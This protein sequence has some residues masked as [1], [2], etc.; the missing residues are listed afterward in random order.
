[1]KPALHVGRV[2]DIIRPSREQL[3]RSD[4]GCSEIL[5]AMNCWEKL[6][7]WT[8]WRTAEFYSG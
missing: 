1:M 4:D 8:S 2:G 3:P 5:E 6:G 7:V